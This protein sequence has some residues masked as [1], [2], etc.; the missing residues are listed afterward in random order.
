MTD[1][2]YDM[3]LVGAGS[4]G[5][6]LA[7]RLS[8]RRDVKVLLLEA[9]G[10]DKAKAIVIPAAFS[11][12]FK[13]SVDWSYETVP[14]EALAGRRLFWPRGK[15]L[16][17]TSSI[18]AMIYVRG[19]RSTFDRWA[20]L[21]NDGWSYEDLLPLFK[22]S[23]RHV[24]GESQFH[25]G[26]GPLC[27]SR[28]QD[29]NPLS[30]AFVDAACAVGLEPNPDFNGARQTGVG[31]YELTQT[32]GKRHSTATAFLKS[33]LSRP[34]LR[35][36]T[37]AL[38]TRVRFEGR[39]ATG[40]DYVQNG[41]SRTAR[42]GQVVLAGGA[43]N[44]PQLLLLSGIGPAEDLE[45]LEIPVVAELP[46]VGRNL[47]D[48][49]QVPVSHRCRRPI[50]LATA[51]NLP[52][53][54]RYLLFKK[55]PL[56][57]NVAEAGGFLRVDESSV[58]PDLQFHFGPSFFIDHGFG[59]PPGHGFGLHPTLVQRGS[60]GRITLGFKSPLESP[61]I[62]PC[63]FSDPADLDLLVAGIRKA[64][65]ILTAA[66]FDEYRGEEWTPG[67][68]V[69]DDEGLREVVRRTAETI[70]HPVGTCKMGSDAEAVVDAR[71]D[72]HG[73]EGLKVADA[74][75]MPTITN[76]NT[77]APS[78]MIGEKAAELIIA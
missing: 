15:V 23:E 16:G 22:R 28:P 3:V 36:E 41:S 30:E 66:P 4:A 71:L 40:V 9:G 42:A 18:N 2:T 57:S 45:R 26:Q 48:H 38:V 12:L 34:N 43:I 64:R 70:Y 13:T 63:Y 17:G 73:V 62:E 53:L 56:T 51:E 72:V 58:A 31:L 19:H 47:S 11:K 69:D 33:A 24:D 6:V 68:E 27:V 44:S 49:L 46:G 37:G 21:G 61:V 14:Q 25:G 52:N 67:A 20:E 50:T 8:A 10:P 78:I 55:G 76:G 7:H 54:L 5:C 29:P 39:R 1:P 77:N 59:N 32:K 35:I 75:I 60:R 65:E 74:S